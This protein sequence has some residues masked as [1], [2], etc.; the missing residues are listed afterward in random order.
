MKTDELISE[1]LA[2]N[3]RALAR[4]VTHVADGDATGQRLAAELYRSGGSASVMGVTGAPGA[5]KSTLVSGLVSVMRSQ[6]DRIAVVAVDPSSPF[7][8][9]A[10]LGDRIRM[11][12]HADDPNV[13]IR[14]VANRGHLGGIAASTPAVTAA[15]DGLG[16]P[17]IVIETVGVGQAEVEIAMACDTT[18]VVVNPGWGDGIQAAKA[19]FLEVADVFV[20]NKADRPGVDATVRDLTSMLELGPTMSWVPPIVCTVAT[21]S[22][23]VDELWEAVTAH[24]SHLAASGDDRHRRH[25]AARH[26]LVGVIRDRIEHSVGAVSDDVVDQLV[27]RSTDPWS[28][29]DALLPER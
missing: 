20:V 11:G 29:A 13:F 22:V 6:R 26:A 25:R 21:E 17:E 7:T 24:R 19:G 15:L 5:G 27:S 23:G 10:I 9:G 16:F 14:S 18:V 28:V 2:G 4:I 3:P 1:A 8:G 12:Q